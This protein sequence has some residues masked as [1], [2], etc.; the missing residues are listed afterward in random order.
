MLNVNY[1]HNKKLMDACKPL[2]E[3]A[4]FINE[5]RKRRKDQLLQSAISVAIQAMP[6]N[7]GI[8]SFVSKHKAEVEGMLDTE[9]NEEEVKELFKEEGREEGRAEERANTS[10]NASVQMTKRNVPMRLKHG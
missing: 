9:Y 2:F 7:F 3:Y 10:V 6:D 4:W 5:I 1:G 8:K